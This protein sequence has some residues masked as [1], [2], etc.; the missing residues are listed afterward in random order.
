MKELKMVNYNLVPKKESEVEAQLGECGAH[1]E[2]DGAHRY[3]ESQ[4]LTTT[5][6]EAEI[7]NLK[8]ALHG[9]GKVLDSATK[10]LYKTQGTLSAANAEVISLKKN[11]ADM[12]R[13]CNT[14]RISLVEEKARVVE[15]ENE[16][17]ILQSVADASHED[18]EKIFQ[19]LRK[20]LRYKREFIDKLKRV[21]REMNEKEI[22]K[23]A[24]FWRMLEDG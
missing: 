16:K 10:L 13:E 22:E 8:S 2:R 6:H 20:E 24:A 3:V 7:T 21:S 17:K 15:L 23:F 1:E 14:L 18:C 4:D 5:T 9:V 11:L 12:E 19:G